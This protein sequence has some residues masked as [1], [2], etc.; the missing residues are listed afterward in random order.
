MI[1]KIEFHPWYVVNFKFVTNF[2]KNEAKKFKKKNLN[3]RLKKTE[4][5]DYYTDSR[6]FFMKI[7]GIGPWVNRI[8]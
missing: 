6:Y 1:L 4:I 8:N 3:G 7:S 2:D 5:F